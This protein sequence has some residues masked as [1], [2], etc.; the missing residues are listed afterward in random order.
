MQGEVGSA[1][2]RWVHH[3]E[4]KWLLDP[5]A[6]V[7]IAVSIDLVLDPRLTFPAWPWTSLAMLASCD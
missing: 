5:E 4:T 7:E 2:P 3:P 6:A 1:W